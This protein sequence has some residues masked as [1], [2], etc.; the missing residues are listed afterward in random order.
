MTKKKKLLII[1]AAAACVCIIVIGVLIYAG[2]IGKKQDPQ[3]TTGG[4]INGQTDIRI[5]SQAEGQT[6]EQ[7]ENK[8]AGSKSELTGS[9]PY[10]ESIGAYEIFPQVMVN[11]DVY[12]W[13]LGK[14]KWLLRHVFMK[15]KQPVFVRELP[16]DCVYYGEIKHVPGDKP[17][18]NCEMVSVFP[19]SGQIYVFPDDPTLCLLV[20]TT[21]EGS[22]IKLDSEIK[23]FYYEHPWYPTGD[24]SD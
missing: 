22:G 6:K 16:E 23:I 8:N 4:L 19:A 15:W 17:T 7:T 14:N 9:S 12:Y 21:P 1:S 13:Y 18:E 5:G 24:N 20:L 2:I 10:M 11:G 3:S